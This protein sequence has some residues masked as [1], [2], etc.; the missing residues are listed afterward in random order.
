MGGSA[1]RIRGFQP[2]GGSPAGDRITHYRPPPSPAF[3]SF[4][5]AAPLRFPRGMLGREGGGG[6]G[7]EDPAGREAAV[8][9]RRWE[10]F[11][12]GPGSCLAAAREPALGGQRPPRPPPH[13][14]YPWGR[15]C[16][17]FPGSPFPTQSSQRVPQKLQPTLL[18]PWALSPVTPLRRCRVPTGRVVS[19]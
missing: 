3:P 13:P 8:P 18:Y 5:A 12:A 6:P 17:P 14:P 4:P 1:G 11:A 9:P 7:W 2:P 19:C 10:K 16:P 15:C